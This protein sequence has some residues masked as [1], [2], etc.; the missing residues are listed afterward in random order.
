MDET[1]V[2]QPPSWQQ[3][4]TITPGDPQHQTHASVPTQVSPAYRTGEQA[5][6]TGPTPVGHQP[7]HEGHPAPAPYVHPSPVTTGRRTDLFD[8]VPRQSLG[9]LVA[10]LSLAA[11]AAIGYFAFGGDDSQ[12]TATGIG[13]EAEQDGTGDPDGPGTAN[14]ASGGDTEDGGGRGVFERG[15]ADDG[16]TDT[17]TSDGSTGTTERQTTSTSSRS[18]TTP[19][20]ANE[21]TT[22]DRQTTTTQRQTTTTE[23]QTT[24][25][26]RETT[27]TTERETTTVPAETPI[28]IVSGP[29][30]TTTGSDRFAF[31]YTT[32]NVCGTGSFTVS[33]TSDGQFIG[34]FSGDNIC[35]GPVHGGF[36]QPSHPVFGGYNLEPNTTYTVRATVRGTATDGSRP[37]GSGS[38]SI[39]FQVTTTG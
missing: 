9:L 15:G 22:T 5:P 39:S 28:R 32:N 26:Q 29:R 10:G 21:T 1:S 8:R 11:I 37:A 3:Q 35:Y 36:P 33:R 31:E 19:S 27:T 24:T 2:Y 13:S 7:A 6:P 18:S 14:S 16:S 38:D 23:R 30:I 17:T 20:T 12:E 34:S 25:T 4:Q